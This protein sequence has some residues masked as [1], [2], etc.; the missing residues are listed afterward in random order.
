[1][2]VET[3]LF[4]VLE[5]EYKAKYIP[6]ECSITELCPVLK[7]RKESWLYTATISLDILVLIKSI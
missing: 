4:S 7:H 3:I 1:M 6:D 5:M 2:H